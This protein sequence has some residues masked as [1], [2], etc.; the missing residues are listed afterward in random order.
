MSSGVPTMSYAAALDEAVAVA[1]RKDDRVFL[2]ANLPSAALTAEFGPQRVRSTPISE[3]AMTGIGVGAALAGKR[4]IVNWRNVTFALNSFDQVAN[5]A[6]KIHYMFGGQRAVPIVFRCLYGGGQRMAAQHSQSPYSIYA[7]VAGLKVV[8]PASPGD[9]FGLLRSAIEDDNP[10]VCFES[11]RLGS[12]H[13]S[14]EDSSIPLGVA[15]TK[16][17]GIDVTVVAIGYMVSLALEAADALDAE[18][19]S[20]EVIDPRTISPLDIE[21]IRGA[22]RR[23]GRLVVVDEAP[24]MCSMAAEIAAAVAEDQ[25][26]FRCLR[27]APMRVSGLPVPIPFSPPLEDQALPDVRRIIEAVRASVRGAAI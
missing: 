22:V 8:I 27:R 25:A 10:I 1:M 17:N 7:H 6:A 9:A 18:G 14:V 5:Q 2:M 11:A 19:V 21:A 3:P 20:V 24:A 15:E 4:P 23:T 16:R 12:V 26:T 13:G